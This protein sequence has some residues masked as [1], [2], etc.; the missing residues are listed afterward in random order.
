MRISQEEFE[1]RY[2][3][4][5]ERMDK[6]GLDCLLIFGLAD[7]FNRGNIRYITGSGRGG[8]CIFPLEG[9]PVL[10]I[11]PLHA[12]SHKLP[13]LIA[14][15]DLIE[16]RQTSNPNEQA[17]LEL[18]HLDKGNKIGVV[19]MSCMSVPVHQMVTEK[20]GDRLMDASKV[21]ESLRVVKSPEEVENIRIAASI[22]DNVYIRLRELVRPGVS[23]YKIYGDVKKMI[24]EM[25]CE[26]SFD[27]IDAAGS[28][29]NMSFYPTDDQLE[30]DGTLFM[31]ITPAYE[32]YYAQ[33]PVTLPVGKYR[34]HVK[35]MV[36]A[37]DQADKA[38]RNI[39]CP[40]NNISDIYHLLI[41]TIHENGFKSPLRPGHSIGLD[42]LDFWSIT[43]SNKEVL[44]P[45][46]TLAIHPCVMKEMGGD[47]CGMGYT[48]LITDVG[49]E[50]FSKID[51]AEEL[52]CI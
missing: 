6:D 43:E 22:A 17:L 48:Y 34:P 26:Y 1:R 11:S 46:M 52:L 25:G 36:N 18:F 15:L 20:F 31:E 47:G 38:V 5:R 37:W 27:L 30:A 45:G 19:G 14:A 29:M 9:T 41:N 23:E 33:L 39:L 21:F 24:Y 10:L 2:L 12:T 13:K 44:K 4:I 32:G 49:Y 7:D 28:T 35:D 40:G 51:L 42:V 50:K 8:C 16:L 3:A